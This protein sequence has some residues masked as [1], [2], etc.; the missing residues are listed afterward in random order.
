MSYI[1]K[2]RGAVESGSLS[3]SRRGATPGIGGGEMGCR[4]M[5]KLG[6]NLLQH[7]EDAWTLC[8][9]SRSGT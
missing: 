1:T 5:A 2:A 8:D 6:Q 3:T 4:V 9:R 7:V